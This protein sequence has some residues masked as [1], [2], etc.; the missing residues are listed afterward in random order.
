MGGMFTK[1]VVTDPRYE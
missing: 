1:Q